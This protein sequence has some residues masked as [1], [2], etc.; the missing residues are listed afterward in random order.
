MEQYSWVSC[1]VPSCKHNVSDITTFTNDYFKADTI[2][3]EKQ[4]LIRMGH[5]KNYSHFNHY[6]MARI[7]SKK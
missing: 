1:F 3:I 4:I 2:V 7:S 6:L 5:Y